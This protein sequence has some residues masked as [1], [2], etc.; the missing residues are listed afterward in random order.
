MTSKTIVITGASDGI[1]AAGARRLHQDGHNVVVVGRSPQKTRAIAHE[2]GADSFVADFATLGE[3]RE[4]AAALDARYPVIDVLVNNAGGI[5]GDRTRTVDGFE[6]TF[7]V[8]HLAPFLL[9]QLLL[10]TLIASSATV[11]QTSSSGARLFGKLAIE[12]L[13]H[14]K[15]FTPQ[16]AYGTVKLEN[17]LF[18]KEL[19]RRYNGQGVSAAAFHP[20]AVATS[21]ATESDSFMRRIY[22]SRLGRALMVSPEKGANQMVWLAE[23]RPGA[24]WH[25]G[26]YY[27]GR[28]PARR[29]N[30]QA[31]DM[32]LARQL[33]D[34]SE[35][36]LAQAAS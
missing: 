36:L 12:D 28:K 8:N 9:T 29:N 14:N 16:L 1:G 27:E 4:L 6:K 3:V 32:D 35:Q 17:I 22:S 10:D 13:N 34:R 15:D 18:T 31:L 23:S 5:F 2:L 24:D 19:H 21:F 30:P 11:I 25:S 33:W 7:Q 26:T 20:G